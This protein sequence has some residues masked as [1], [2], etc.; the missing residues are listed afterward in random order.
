MDIS[1]VEPTSRHAVSSNESSAATKGAAA[2]YMEQIKINKYSNREW[3]DTVPFI[4]ESSGYLGKRAEALL[5]KITKESPHLRTW[6]TG[7]LS[8][9]LARS[10]GRM[11]LNSQSLLQ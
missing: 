10:E 1:I 2:A 11:R 8:L 5:E 6:F 3:L 4:L 9:L 7:E